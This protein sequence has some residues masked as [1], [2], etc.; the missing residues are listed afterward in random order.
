MKDIYEKYR[1]AKNWEITFIE[2]NRVSD[3]VKRPLNN[4]VLRT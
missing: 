1:E 2:E 3:I 4:R